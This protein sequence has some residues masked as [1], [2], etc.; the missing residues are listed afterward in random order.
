MPAAVQFDNYG[1]IEVLDV[2]DV[3]RPL[4]GPG[5]AVVQVKA[6]S[7]NPGEAK[8]REG[9]LHELYPATFPSGEGSD[10]AGVVQAIGDGVDDLLVGD[11]VIGFTDN[12]ASHAEFVL[13]EVANLTPRPTAVPW[14]IAGSLYVAGATAYATV[15]AVGASS[16]DVVVVAGAAGGVGT[17]AVQLA[18]IKGAMVIALASEPHHGWLREHGA[19][20]VT[21]GDGVAERI[22]AAAGA[23]PDAFIDL[24]GGDYVE[25]ALG[26]GVAPDRIDTI[27]NFAAKE[28]HGV[29]T[30]G[31]AE[32]A[33]AEVLAELASLI[34]EGKLELPIAATYPLARVRDAFTEL[35]NGHTLGKIVLVP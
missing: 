14:E 18:A 3:P 21:Y 27:V 32:G 30:E 16:G 4:A 1:A 29:K 25:I 34:A 28:L 8:I 19:I 7:I 31:N 5:Q 11:E 13:A 9:F 23:S 6:T 35:A 22:T 2:R 12:R 33:S 26:L 10:F 15:R 24:A 17:I 20:P